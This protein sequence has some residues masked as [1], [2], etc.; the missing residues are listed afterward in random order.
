MNHTDAQGAGDHRRRIEGLMDRYLNRYDRI[1]TSLGAD[2]E[3]TAPA[4]DRRDV[5]STTMNGLIHEQLAR[6]RHREAYLEAHR[7]RL[8]RAV[9]AQG[10]ARRAAEIAA[11]AVDRAAVVLRPTLG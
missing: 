3:A 5:R 9:R 11:R 1:D 8:R 4:I 2:P 7:L 10:R 6:Q